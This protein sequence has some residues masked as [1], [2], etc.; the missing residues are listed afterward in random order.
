MPFVKGF[1]RI[2][3]R[4][5]PDIGL[6]DPEGE[7]DPDF[8][9]EEL[10][11]GLG[12]GPI[13]PEPPP[14]IWPPLT[15]EMPWRPIDPSWGVGRPPLPDG[16]L[17]ERP[18]R[19]ERPTDPGYGIEGPEEPETLPPGTLWPPLPPGVSGKFLA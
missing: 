17:P 7:I 10:P 3:R 14:G 9:L 5:Q 16:G 12:G 8:G 15:P 6:P 2:R 19:P 11:P 13:I 1:L 4:G 18:G